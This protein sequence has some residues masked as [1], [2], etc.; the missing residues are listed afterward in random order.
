MAEPDPGLVATLEA[1]LAEARDQ[2]AELR[3][4]LLAVVAVLDAREPH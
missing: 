4:A 2:Q 1:L 3:A